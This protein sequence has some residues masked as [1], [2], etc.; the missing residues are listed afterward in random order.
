MIT[1]N[2]ALDVAI[3][4]YRMSNLH[5]VQAACR[6]VGLKSVVTSE[7]NLILKAKATILPGVG[8]FGEA[9][10]RLKEL[11]LDKC[12]M[13]FISA[14]KPFWGICL[15][16]QLLFSESEE[17]GWHKGLGILEGRVKK[18]DF[19]KV[20][21]ERYP[22][23]QIGWN[24]IYQNDAGWDG[25]LL[26]DN[27]DQDFMYFVHSYYVIPSDLSIGIAYTTYGTT[28]YCSALSWENVFASQFHPET[29]G[30]NGLKIYEN[31]K[32]RIMK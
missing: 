16:M 22:V 27:A 23:P 24:R 28:D 5:S 21:D 10:T 26:K 7:C 1:P 32:Q 29:S 2:S 11:K 31:L 17:H 13:D 15:G 19:Q 3:I 20:T 18:F 14:G 12:I 9:M 6:K 25:T 4:D 30:H 8:A